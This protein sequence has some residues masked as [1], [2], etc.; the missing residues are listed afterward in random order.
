MTAV[1]GNRVAFQP[2]L[3]PA[4]TPGLNDVFVHNEF[5]MDSNSRDAGTNDNPRFVIAPILDNVLGVKL[6]SAQIPF[7][8]Y[9]FNSRNNTFT[10]TSTGGGPF[11]VTIP[12]GN[13]TVTSLAVALAAAMN[14]VNP[15]GAYS[16]T[17]SATTGR[18]TIT[19]GTGGYSF[20][21]TFTDPGL[22]LD[23]GPGALSPRLWIGFPAGASTST[24]GSLT[25]PYV[26]NVTGPTY[27]LVLA[28]L[29][30]RIAKNVRVNG[31]NSEDP[32][33]LAKI[34]VNVNPGGLILFNDP[35]ESYAFDMSDSFL[36]EMEFSLHFG[37]SNLPVEMNGQPWSL[38][39]QIL[40]KRDT[41]ISKLGVSGG[42]GDSGVMRGKSKRVRMG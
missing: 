25:A 3:I 33:V 22:L 4:Q 26:A 24:A 11:T 14:A 9:V 21:L 12:V 39:L 31:L 35:S 15:G 13:Y 10:L 37:D 40:T 28:S 36:Q 19:S 5:N 16:V 20:T 41:S 29:G 8:Y 34:P 6:I 7:S 42:V 17:Y 18:F 2:D 27:L 38:V 1:N 30:A 23:E 32:P